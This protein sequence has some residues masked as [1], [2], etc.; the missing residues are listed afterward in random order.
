MSTFTEVP[1]SGQGRIDA[2]NQVKEQYENTEAAK[3]LLL[4]GM[5]T[6]MDPEKATA[7]N[8]Q[9]EEERKLLKKQERDKIKFTRQINS[10][11]KRIMALKVVIGLLVAGMA[12]AV[13]VFFV[14]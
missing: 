8:K 5:A 12:G 9:E 2:L 1:E 4:S 10:K 7:I 14:L 3:Q 11:N 6:P 13:I